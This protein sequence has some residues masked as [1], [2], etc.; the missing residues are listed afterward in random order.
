MYWISVEWPGFMRFFLTKN[1]V[2]LGHSFLEMLSQRGDICKYAIVE[3]ALVIPSKLTHS[4]IKPAFGSCYGLIRYKWFS[5]LQFKFL[6]IKPTLFDEYYRDTCAITKENMIAFLQANALYGLKEKVANS[7]AIVSIYVGSKENRVMHISAKK[8]H[9]KLS[10]SSLYVIPKLYHGEFSIN[11]ASIYVKTIYA[12]IK[13]W[14]NQICRVDRISICT[15][16]DRGFAM[17]AKKKKF[18]IIVFVVATLIDSA[19]C[20][21]CLG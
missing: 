6:H 7:N 16:K 13:Q 1:R 12:M 10:R 2:I 3:S 21:D 19:D 11:N 5:R 18:I 9:E 8:I 15:I 4:L 17:A 14:Q 20:L